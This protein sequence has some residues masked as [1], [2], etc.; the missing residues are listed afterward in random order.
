[1]RTT[2]DIKTKTIDDIPLKKQ[3][4]LVRADL[5]VPLNEHSEITDFTRIEKA[6]ETLWSLRARGCKIILMSHLGQPHGRD[7]KYS[8]RA[9]K[10]KLQ[11]IFPDL[12]MV[13]DCIGPEVTKA[14]ASLQN[15]QILLL[16]NL[17]YHPGEI[18]NDTDFALQLSQLGDVYVNDAF[19]ASHRPHASIVGVGRLMPAVA[20]LL[21]AQE[22]SALDKISHNPPSPT[23]AIIGGAK[24]SSK[25]HVLKNLIKKYDHLLLGGALA[26]TFLVAQGYD[27]GKSFYEAEQVSTARQ[28]LEVAHS[29]KCQLWLPFDVV[30]TAE[31]HQTPRFAQIEGITA[32]DKIYD[33]GPQTTTQWEE[34]ISNAKTIL[35]NGPLGMYEEP[36]F[37]TASKK[38]ARIIAKASQEKGAIS[39][40]GGGET[41]ALLNKTNSHQQFTHVSLGGGALLEWLAGNEL[42][43]VNCLWPK[44]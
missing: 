19:S 36:Q 32:Q 23:V 43:G 12:I 38:I 22:L 1:M 25:I 16:E 4:V 6:C 42:P 34:I 29:G 27:I 31:I 18:A 44:V 21:M 5:N 40:A 17:R 35:W 33:I 11:E 2:S 15:S 9:I 3:K 14:A 20:G 41:V 8:L 39:I 30:V 24:V 28:L 7:P 37:R 13:D 26:N 10:P